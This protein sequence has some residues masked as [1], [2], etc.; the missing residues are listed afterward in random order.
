[1]NSVYK[2]IIIIILTLLTSCSDNR[3]DEIANKLQ[4]D[5]IPNNIDEGYFLSFKGNMVSNSENEFTRYY[6]KDDTII[7]PKGWIN[8]SL[9]MSFQRVTNKYI[10]FTHTWNSKRNLY[11]Y[12]TT[13]TNYNERIILTDIEIHFQNDF[14]FGLNSWAIYLNDSL[15]C[16][17]GAFY[18]RN[19]GK[20]SPTVPGEK[21]TY[22]SKLT[23]KEFEFIQRKVRN[24]NLSSLIDTYGSFEKD[25]SYYGPPVIY[26][27]IHY[28]V[29]DS[30]EIKGAKI[31]FID[32]ENPPT[33]VAIL[34]NYLHQLH[35]FVSFKSTNKTHNFKRITSASTPT[36]K[37]GWDFEDF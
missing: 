16:F 28:R 24:I 29:K 1:M 26:L 11:P 17:L 12:I 18:V 23:T 15:D 37:Y 20:G 14:Y 31:R 9:K 13:N 33:T 10:W 35:Y 30:N 8:S 2:I 32:Y 27:L 21:G 22:Y 4:G 6:I 34:I 5:W 3:N 19:R 7:I 36:A 25:R